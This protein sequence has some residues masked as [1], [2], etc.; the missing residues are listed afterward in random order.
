MSHYPPQYGMRGRGERVEE[1]KAEE[2][3]SEHQLLLSVQKGLWF[4]VLT[5]LTNLTLDKN[6]EDQQES[7]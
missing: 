3:P 2:Q 5:N 1:S 7:L 4:P 6:N